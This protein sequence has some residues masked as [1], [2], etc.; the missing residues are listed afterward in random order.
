MELPLGKLD[1]KVIEPTSK[2]LDKK[3]I[4]TTKVIFMGNASVGKTSII[5]SFMENCS[6]REKGPTSTKVI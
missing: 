2:D 4:K 3:Q 5:S 1:T 6:M